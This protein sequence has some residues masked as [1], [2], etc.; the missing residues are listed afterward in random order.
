MKTFM[1]CLWLIPILVNVYI[2]RNGKKPN[3]LIVNTLRGMAAI[4][5]GVLFDLACHIFPVEWSHYTYWETF[6]IFLPLIIFWTTSYWIIFEA[7][8]NKVRGKEFFYFDTVEH[9]SGLIDRL[10]SVLGERA[11]FVAKMIAL[12]LCIASMTVI[13]SW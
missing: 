2:D 9:D 6:L 11:H 1:F 10:F 7:V 3:Y 12:F 8:L 4:V 5:H 13:Y